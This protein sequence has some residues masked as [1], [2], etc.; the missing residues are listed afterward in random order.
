MVTAC[1]IPKQKYLDYL[2]KIFG[3]FIRKLHRL[4]QS[5]RRSNLQIA[6]INNNVQGVQNF[7]H[8]IVIYND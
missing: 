8:Q 4:E 2:K 5:D 7:C 6:N 1:H 3:L